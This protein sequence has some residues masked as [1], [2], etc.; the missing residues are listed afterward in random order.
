MWKAQNSL[1]GLENYAILFL[2]FFITKTL[3]NKKKRI[4]MV[5]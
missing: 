1:R 3:K 5:G 2:L 4:K